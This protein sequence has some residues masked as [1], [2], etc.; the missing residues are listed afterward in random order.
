MASP[1]TFCSRALLCCCACVTIDCWT[2]VHVTKYTMYVHESYV[3][4]TNIHM[5]RYK[6][7][8]LATVVI[9]VLTLYQP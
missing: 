1:Q 9:Y 5:E 6:W 2:I 3:I 4:V 8:S 7:H